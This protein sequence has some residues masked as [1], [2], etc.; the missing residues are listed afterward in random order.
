MRRSGRCRAQ[1]SPHTACLCL[2]AHART[3][4][5]KRAY[6]AHDR[7]A[8]PTPHPHPRLAVCRMCLHGISVM[9]DDVSSHLY[10]GEEEEEEETSLWH[11]AYCIFIL[12]SLLSAILHSSITICLARL[13][14]W[15][16]SCPCI[17]GSWRVNRTGM[18]QEDSLS[19]S[20]IF[21]EDI[22]PPAFKMESF[23][24]HYTSLPT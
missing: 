15:A 21:H 20:R 12:E 17:S 11:C 7:A 9:Y 8:S 23:R 6:R 24:D 4:G 16:G 5:D 13:N 18:E 10:R 14:R 19:F 1:Y 3:V 22:W 2:S